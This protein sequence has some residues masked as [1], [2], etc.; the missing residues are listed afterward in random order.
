MLLKK[1]R[2]FT[3]GPTALLP[4][5]Q[6]AMAA[7]ALHHRTNEFRALFKTTRER[8][9]K[10]LGT[11]ND[12]ILLTAS[13]SGAMES[14]V[15]NLVSPGERVLV[16]SAGKFGER[17]QKIAKVYGCNIDL[18]QLPYGESFGAEHVKGRLSGANAAQVL[19]VQ[20][21]ESSTG[22]K[23]DI[24]AIARA[25]RKENPNV[26]LLI[27]GITGVGTQPLDIDAWDLDIVI[28]GSQKAVM[29]APG[30]AYLSVSERAWKAMESSKTPRFYFD[31]RNERKSQVNGETCF[32]PAIGLVAALNAALEYIESIGG[33]AALV[34]N[35]EALGAATRAALEALG[36][37][38]FGNGAP[39]GA[40][41]A[42][43]MPEGFDSGLVI[44]ALREQFGT[45]VANGQGEMKGKMIRVAHLGYYDFPELLSVVAQLEIILAQLGQFD[46][47]KL[48]A[49]VRAAQTYYLA[50]HKAAG[51]KA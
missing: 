42:I 47:A 44:K 22:C 36:L 11:K 26:L 35:A 7:M 18:V 1:E 2:L 27:D 43:A 39:S 33:C 14:A 21:S 20:A 5:A 12:V 19:M 41:T 30:L 34:A 38:R 16:M 29:M 24:A 13:G 8:L 50:Q 4:Q 9:Q 17:W 37:K 6:A 3:P 49:G 46:H 23:H 48:G 25:A 40:L 32:T 15:T 45:V 51:A 10:F 31:L 28:G